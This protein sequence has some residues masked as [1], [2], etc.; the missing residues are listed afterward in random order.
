MKLCNLASL[1][2]RHQER[3]IK[4]LDSTSKADRE[5]WNEFNSDWGR[6]GVESEERFQN[7]RSCKE[8]CVNG[9]FGLLQSRHP[10]F[11]YYA[12]LIQC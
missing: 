10:A 9:F 12:E 8:F 6:F 11:K 7:L 1:D 3:G 5:I 4:G 2:P